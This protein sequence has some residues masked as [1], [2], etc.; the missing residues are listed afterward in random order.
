MTEADAVA[1]VEDPVTTDDIVSDLRTLG[2]EAGDTLLV[3]ASLSE[4]GWVCGGPQAV[5][6]ALRH[7][8]TE[9]GTLVMPTH[10]GQYSNPDHW[11]NPPVPDHWPDIIRETM[12]PYRPESTPTRGMGAVSECFRNYPGVHRSRHPE[13]S[14][15]AWGD[16]AEAIV[17]DHT[18]DHGLGEE[19]PLAELY[20]RDAKVLMLGTDWGTFTTLHLAEYRADYETEVTANVAPVLEDGERVLAE[21]EDIDIDDDDFPDIG[22]AFEDRH[23]SAVTREKV[24]VAESTLVSMPE[25]VDFGVE[26]MSANR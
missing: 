5:V 26:W 16:D 1:A 6:D 9:D 25:L 8:L 21:Y 15:A 23:E 24:G 17:A 4:L 13:V 18:F 22:A 19:S 3:H 10:S 20:D 14:F 11:E 7:V 12:P 2:V